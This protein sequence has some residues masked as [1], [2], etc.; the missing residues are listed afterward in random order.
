MNMM[1]Y[2]TVASFLSLSAF[3]GDFQQRTLEAAHDQFRSATNAAMYAEAAGQFEYLV[4]DEGIRNGRLFYNIANCWFMANEPGRAILNYRRAQLYLPNDPDIG[5]NLGA[6]LALRT[7]L[8]PEKEPH[9]LAVRMLGWHCGTSLSTRWWMFAAC[10]IVFW[11]ACF[12]IQKSSRREARIALAVSGILSAALLISISAEAWAKGRSD[13]GVV[14]AKEVL[15]RKGDS[16]MYAPAFL[17]PLHS[18]TEFRRLEDRGDW[19]HIELADGRTCWIPSRAAER[20][21]FN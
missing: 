13:Q 19:W 18:G 20:V 1:H 16:N 6:A 11:G 7:D 5:H 14:V 21:Q 17:E 2:M 4:H 3:G 12:W 10:W 8:I 15:A 9:P